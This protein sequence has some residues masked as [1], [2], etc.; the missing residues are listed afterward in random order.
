[1][2]DLPDET[3][4][5]WWSEGVAHLRALVDEL[6]PVV[7]PPGTSYG[8]ARRALGAYRAAK[9]WLAESE[10]IRRE[11]PDGRLAR[12][13]YRPSAVWPGQMWSDGVADFRVTL[14]DDEYATLHEVGGGG[15]RRVEIVGDGLGVGLEGLRW[16]HWDNPR[17]AAASRG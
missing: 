10:Q 5:D 16:L 3:V 11:R 1:M 9:R 12:L 8:D 6:A 4:V 2:V 7:F 17:Y 14:V 13:V 15:A